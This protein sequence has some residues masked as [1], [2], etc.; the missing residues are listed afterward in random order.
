LGCGRHAEDEADERCRESVDDEVAPA[1]AQP[2]GRHNCR[3]EATQVR[4]R[5]D[6]DAGSTR[7][8]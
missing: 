3:A 6:G 2:E 4:S 7:L 5:I 1:A 8:T